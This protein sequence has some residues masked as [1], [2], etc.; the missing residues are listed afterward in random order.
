MVYKKETSLAK[1]RGLYLFLKYN[2]GG[3][4]LI[5]SPFT[6]AI[7]RLNEVPYEVLRGYSFE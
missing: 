7:R 6:Y 1:Y 2:T 3:G 5:P 4:G